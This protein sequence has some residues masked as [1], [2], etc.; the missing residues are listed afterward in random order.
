MTDMTLSLRDHFAAAALQGI[1]AKHGVMRIDEQLRSHMPE[2]VR[3][4]F[5]AYALWA[6]QLADAMLEA[7]RKRDALGNVVLTDKERIE[8]IKKEIQ[9]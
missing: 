7:G 1:I 2:D 9:R 8:Q 6:Y 5:K 3:D 4:Y